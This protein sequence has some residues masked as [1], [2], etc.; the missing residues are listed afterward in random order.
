MI[1]VTHM[2]VGLDMSATLDES[3]KLQYFDNLNHCAAFG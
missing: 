2:R 3:D 1:P